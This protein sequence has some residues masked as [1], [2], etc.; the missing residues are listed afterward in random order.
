ML[1]AQPLPDLDCQG[2]PA[3]DVHHRQ[4]PELLAIAELVVD[5]VEAPGFIGPFGLATRNAMHDHLAPTGL[6]CP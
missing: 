5:E 4:R 2:L 3:E 1:A 6:L